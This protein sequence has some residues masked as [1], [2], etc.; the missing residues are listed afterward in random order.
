MV[1]RSWCNEDL[2]VVLKGTL[3]VEV[4]G[5]FIGK[6]IEEP[7]VIQNVS[8]KKTPPSLGAPASRAAGMC[9][10]LRP[11]LP[12]NALLLSPIA[13]PIPPT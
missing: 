10:V 12:Q 2:R 13:P 5:R 4:E 8:K 7:L 3:L 6:Q 1:E 9:T 11:H